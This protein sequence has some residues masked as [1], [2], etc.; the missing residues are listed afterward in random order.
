[1]VAYSFHQCFEGSII[2]YRKLQT[3]R[4]HRRRHARPGEPMQLYT[5]MRTRACRKLL[6]DDPICVSLDDIEIDVPAIPENVHFVDE[7]LRISVDG[8][9]LSDVAVEVFAACDGFACIT[10]KDENG[11][12]CGASLHLNV[13]RL[14]TPAQLM[15]SFWHER[16]GPGSWSGVLIRW[17]PA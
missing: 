6:A 14:L 17:R 10:A 3:V 4:G 8:E 1:M 5:G 2:A 16:Y 9:Q 12:V 13:D 7:R 11:L 15:T